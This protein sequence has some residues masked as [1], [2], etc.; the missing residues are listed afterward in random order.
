LVKWCLAGGAVAAIWAPEAIA[1][2]I[3]GSV[4]IIGAQA[5]D[6]HGGNFFYN[7]FRKCISHFRKICKCNEYAKAVLCCNISAACSNNYC[8]RPETLKLLRTKRQN[9]ALGN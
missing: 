1:T 3:I 5:Y 7:F 4:L 9:N 6:T 2:K 8:N